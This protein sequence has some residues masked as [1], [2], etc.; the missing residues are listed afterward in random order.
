VSDSNGGD[1]LDDEAIFWESFFHSL[2]PIRNTYSKF[3]ESLSSSFLG[4]I[5]ETGG[6]LF[7]DI[8]DTFNSAARRI[9]ELT[10]STIL[11][12][13]GSIVAV[14]LLLTILIGKD[15]LDFEHQINGDVEIYLPDGADSTELLEN[16]REQWATDIV[17]L[18][19]QT[20]NAASGSEKGL[21]NITDENILS[22]I[23]WI[24][25]DD[26][27]I[28][29]SGYQRGL[30]Y[31][32]SDRGESDGVIWILSPAQ[33]IKEANSSN[34]RF[35]CAAEKYGLPS[36]NQEDCSFS[37][38]NS[39]EGYS[40]PQGED[41]QERIDRYVENS[42]E[43][44][45]RPGCRSSLVCDT[46]N[47]GIWDT[48]V[49]IMGIIF[50]M[51]ETDIDQRPDPKDPQKEIRDHKAFLLYVEKLVRN[52]CDLPDNYDLLRCR[53]YE[54]PTSTI[55][56]E[57]EEIICRD[58]PGELPYEGFTAENDKFCRNAMTITG[59][60]P[61]LHDVSDAI[62]DELVDTMLPLSLLFVALT[63]FILHR[64][65]KVIIICGLPIFM[66]LAVT[67]G[68]TVI[69]DIMLT[70]M[71]ISAGPILVGLGVDYALHLTNRI[72]ENRS[73]IIDEQLE[74]A[75]A[76][77]RDGLQTNDID[78]WSPY[79][80]LTATVRSAMTTGHAIFISAVTT[81]IGFSVLTW[82]E[83]VPIEPMRT[84]GT[85]LLIGIA[86][87]FILS[88]L[89][90][91]AL[92]HLL[93]YRKGQLEFTIS[94]NQIWILSILISVTLFIFLTRFLSSISNL[95]N[96]E[97]GN[98]LLMALS[99]GITII[100]S[101]LPGLWEKIGELPIK[102]T[103]LILIL[104]LSATL[105]GVN[106]FTDELGKEITGSSDEVPPGLESYETLREY[107]IE[108]KGGQTN[109]FI[110]DA[111]DYVN[112]TNSAPI[113]DLL[114]LDAIEEAQ[115]NNLDNVR[116][117]TT[118]SLVNILKAVHVDVEFVGLELYGQSLWELL[119]DECWDESSNPLRPDC[120]TYSVS[121][122]EDI[123]NIVFDT[124][125]P[126]IRS[127]LM[128]ADA[129]VGETKTLVYVNQPYINLAE[130]SSLRNAID[131]YLFGSSCVDVLNCNTLGIDG[132]SNSLLTGGLPVSLDIN[133]GIHD[134]QSDS[135]IVT[136]L[137]LL[138]V[139]TMLFRSPRLAI[140]TMAAVGAVVLWQ[141]I[142]MR[143]GDVNVNVFTAMI[144]TIVFGIG[145]DD[146]IH[147]VDR[148]KDEKETPAG[149]VKSISRTGHTIFETTVTTCAG[150]SAGLF[151]AIPGLQNFF[152]LM[153]LLLVLALITSS[154]LLPTMI[155]AYNEFKSRI[156]GNG[157][158]LDYE[159][160]GTIS[161]ESSVDAVI[162]K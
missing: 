160:S 154:I 38:L 12:S 155:V 40:I 5:Y 50:D 9:T 121:N 105:Y 112:P 140:F 110:V 83:I 22:Q 86:S 60:T 118:I 19:V 108:F 4:E 136:M 28:K 79:I 133:K 31:D 115:V 103:L 63:M 128:N 23:S 72:E 126:E 10:Y 8:S 114:I 129:G 33:M 153:M 157:T 30:D 52:D 159:G 17:M 137:I 89:M 44:L 124:L 94:K 35:S 145:V 119:H 95:D 100:V 141:P 99:L 116:N 13:P 61:V 37:S 43:L 21:E 15:A 18:Y 158:W 14:L 104:S 134:A 135:T 78:P 45:N 142:L 68:T 93:R 113:R 98:A 101:L 73:E 149:I 111:T 107:S 156:S 67:F 59:L 62:Y 75:W 55:D 146:S 53:I 49:V 46:N 24:E 117:T 106:L 125:S 76:A 54:N 36:G 152:I 1:E 26:N 7:D 131:A 82:T 25:G 6:Q 20:N 97:M 51:S 58:L 70:P 123:I 148:I 47:D 65:P 151:V 69:A 11:R 88:M 27:N 92:I 41:A 32:K 143:L 84:V 122:R 138:L 91:P 77:Q 39:F 64:D 109:M 161:P 96:M 74:M 81:I 120:W 80:S 56:K 16:V 90:V 130:A 132:V 102:A 144:G 66:S 3:K 34:Y 29:L 48:G 85:T 162:S 147:I 139:M 2:Q 71:I 127:M 87:T 57:R 150:L 42:G